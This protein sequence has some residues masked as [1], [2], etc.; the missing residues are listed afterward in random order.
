MDSK[1][2]LPGVLSWEAREVVTTWPRAG[3]PRGLRHRACSADC[4]A[5][6]GRAGEGLC[7]DSRPQT[8][9]STRRRGH[10]ARIGGHPC[11]PRHVEVH[12]GASPRPCQ[13]LT[14]ALC[15]PELLA[16]V[17]LCAIPRLCAWLIS[18]D[19]G[20]SEACTPLHRRGCS[21]ASGSWRR[22]AQSAQLWLGCGHAPPRHQLRS[23]LQPCESPPLRARGPASMRHLLRALCRGRTNSPGAQLPHTL[24]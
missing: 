16:G 13:H 18:W 15:A 17:L 4:A 12:P 9:R 20:P 6:L 2:R 14:Q 8:Q 24:C 10:H 22:T 7:V 5:T 1:T 19:S 21:G 3:A 11:R 23:A